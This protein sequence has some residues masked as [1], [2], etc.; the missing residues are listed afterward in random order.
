MGAA[1]RGSDSQR[2][3]NLYVAAAVTLF[4]LSLLF[5]PGEGGML[6]LMWRDAPGL[7]LLLVAAAAVC[8]A[9]AWRTPRT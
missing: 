9:L 3:R 5:A 7:A 1:R 8:A 2:K 4:A 6:W